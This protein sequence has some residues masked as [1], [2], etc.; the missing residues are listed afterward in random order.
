MLNRLWPRLKTFNDETYPAVWFAVGAIVAIAF[1]WGDPG[2]LAGWHLTGFG[3]SVVASIAGVFL[4]A[5]LAIGWLERAQRR[6]AA[7]IATGIRER[8]LRVRGSTARIAT[9]MVANL[10]PS[11]FPNF[12]WDTS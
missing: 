12:C 11:V 8:L 7:Q 4:A 9:M 5:T 10:F 1:G 3:E 2:R 6:Q